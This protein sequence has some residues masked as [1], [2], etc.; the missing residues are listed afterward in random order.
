MLAA[1]DELIPAVSDRVTVLHLGG[2]LDDEAQ[3]LYLRLAGS[4]V[5]LPGDDTGALRVLARW[6]AGRVQPAGCSRPA[7]RCASPGP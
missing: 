6:C 7:S 1:H 5:P 4:A 2:A 3:D